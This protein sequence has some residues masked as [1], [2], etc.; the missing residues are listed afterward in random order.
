VAGLT[1]RQALLGLQ[2]LKHKG[3][4]VAYSPF[5]DDVDASILSDH[6]GQ[7]SPHDFIFYVGQSVDLG[8]IKAFFVE[9]SSDILFLLTGFVNPDPSHDLPITVL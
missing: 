8:H 7:L 4:T 2:M 5:C 6:V 3:F 9:A 1:A